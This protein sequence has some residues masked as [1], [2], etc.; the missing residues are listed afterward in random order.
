MPQAYTPGLRV[1]PHTTIRKQR[2]LPLE[3][4]VLV[5]TGDVVL[6]DQIVAMADLPGNV[7]TLNLVNRLGC[8]AEEL[9]DL[10]LKHEG[11]AVELDEPIAQT[12]PLIKWFKTSVPSPI[13][14]AI[15][16]VSRVTGQVLLREPPSPVELLAS[17][18]ARVV[19]IVPGQGVT[20][21][22]RGLIFRG[23]SGWGGRREVF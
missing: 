16:S 22:L 14:G 10:M 4:E 13:T 20:S 15:E 2:R 7:T 9:P 11:D 19:D 17:I 6:R 8:S 1:T 23:F 18:D 3:G 5:S 12:R 21:K